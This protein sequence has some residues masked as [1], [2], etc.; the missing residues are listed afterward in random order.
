MTQARSLR[1]SIDWG[2]L[3][4]L[5]LRARLVAEGAL[6]G[7]HRSTRRGSGV[8]FGGHRTY[9]PG[10]DLRFLDRRAMMRHDRL[11]VREFET[12][13]ERG[14]RLLVDASRSMAYRSE[15]AP[16]DKIAFAAVIAAALARIALADSDTVSLDF[17]G[18]LDARPVPAS[19]GSEA[20]ARI[21]AALESLVPSGDLVETP[22]ELDRALS[23]VAQ[24]ARRGSIVVVLS[25]FLDLP[26]GFADRLA[27][28]ST[29]G[30]V[31]VGIRVLD[32]VEATFPFHG[33]LRLRASEGRG[34]VETDGDAARARYLTALSSILHTYRERL[35]S[36]GGQLLDATT[37]DDPVIVVQRLLAS[38][39]GARA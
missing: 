25:D 35:V 37:A 18:G 4:P 13:T 31:V 10:D 19:G 7:M 17:F 36:S 2:K 32:P 15:Q 12:D 5:H 27:A 39:H 14:V 3:G 29:G 20:F 1:A 26:P 8:E 33:P 21:V 30:R 6:V 16:A 24:R 23:R 9:V 38:L 28:L 11:F 22:E 34:F